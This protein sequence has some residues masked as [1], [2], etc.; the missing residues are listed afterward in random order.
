MVVLPGNSLGT[1]EEF[2]AGTDT[3][4]E[5]VDILATHAGETSID[6]DHRVSIKAVKKPAMLTPGMV[7]FG[8]VDEIFEPIAL[9]RVVGIEQNGVRP[10]NNQF[11]CVLHVSRI[12]SGYAKNVRDEI[13]IGDIV[14]AVVDE[15]KNEEAHLSTKAPEF[16]VIKAFCSNCRHPLEKKERMLECPDCGS[17]ENRKLAPGYRSV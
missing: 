4:V 10:V 13:K 11:Y 1:E 8:R 16:G 6:A 14:K 9:L 7:V 17:K 3:F 15:I 2:L 5:G 12:K